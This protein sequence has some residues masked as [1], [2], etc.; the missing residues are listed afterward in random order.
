MDNTA[1]ID[2]HTI[3]VVLKKQDHSISLLQCLLHSAHYH[4]D[5]PENKR[6]SRADAG[7][8]LRDCG[9]TLPG[10]SLRWA[11]FTIYHTNYSF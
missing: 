3:S 8:V 9:L 5:L 10:P 7:I 4:S 11:D 2:L 1:Q 6:C